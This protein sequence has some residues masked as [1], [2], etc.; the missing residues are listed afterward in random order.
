MRRRDYL[1]GSTCGC[2]H[3]KRLRGGWYWLKGREEVLRLC[4]GGGMVRGVVGCLE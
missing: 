1:I 4:E 2:R 3:S